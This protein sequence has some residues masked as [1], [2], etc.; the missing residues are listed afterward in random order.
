M[1]TSGNTDYNK[2][3]EYF[4]NQKMSL[5]ELE[6]QYSHLLESIWSHETSLEHIKRLQNEV[7]ELQNEYNDFHN[8]GNNKKIVDKYT[9]RLSKLEKIKEIEEELNRLN[10]AGK[11]HT[12]KAKNL[13]KN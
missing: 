2:L 6:E 8:K 7:N 5:E 13:Q 1:P 9:D 12:K 11:L 10:G 4:N 3:L